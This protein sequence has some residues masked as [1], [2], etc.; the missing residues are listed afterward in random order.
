MTN[1][2]PRPT[3]GAAGSWWH[4]TVL[5]TDGRRVRCAVVESLRYPDGT[6]IELV[7]PMAEIQIGDDALCVASFGE[8][9]E[10]RALDVSERFASQAPPIWFV[11]LR[12]TT[13]QPPAV[14]LLAFTG[15]GIERSR[16]LDA[17]AAAEAGVGREDQLGALRWYPATGET[18]QLYVQPQWR[19]RHVGATLLAAGNTLSV[20]R[21][22]PRFWGDGQ[23]TLLGEQARNARSWR[24]RTAELIH[25]APPMTPGDAG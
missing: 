17:Q 20:A 12:E 9:G 1:G 14:H 13:A 21:G 7:E 18:D 10:V 15:H 2:G 3:V 19:R 5:A 24:A 22:W 4:C 23:R 11:E 25:L 8:S 16:L 6:H